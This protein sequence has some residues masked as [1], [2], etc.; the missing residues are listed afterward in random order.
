LKERKANVIQVLQMCHAFHQAGVDTTLAIPKSNSGMTNTEIVQNELGIPAGFKIQEYTKYTV[1]GRPMTLGAYWGI[2]SILK[3]NK[4]YDYCYVRNCFLAGLVINSGFRTIYEEHEQK[5]HPLALL[6]R[7]YV[8]RLFSTIRSANMVKIIVISQALRY[9]WINQGIPSEKI[10]VLHDGVA[11]D[12]YKILKTRNQARSELGIK[13][14]KKIVVYVGSLYKDRGI[15]I[16]LKL[17]G[18]FPDVCFM[19][20]GG[21]AKDKSD[22]ELK[23]I[24]Q[25]LSNI[26]F[27]GRVPHYKVK[28][29]LCAADVLLMLW[30]EKT[31]T[32][33]ICS[34]LK[35]FEYMAAGKIIV[36]YGFETVKEVCSDEKN[37]LLATPC[38]FDELKEKLHKA[39]LLDYPNRLAENARK[40][41]FEK[42][43]WQKRVQQILNIL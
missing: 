18:S 4:N 37:A 27:T 8:K 12:D 19:I 26:I 17:A 35:L 29:Y 16:I 31:P 5:L 7:W 14:N 9:A 28:D 3:K 25:N 24:K 13:T 40:L 6:N 21:P 34:P 38:S 32:I 43:S 23:A 30:T 15:E 39:L 36:G 1:C 42:Y 10:M 11:V 41:V 22:Y 20:V 2:K 33:D